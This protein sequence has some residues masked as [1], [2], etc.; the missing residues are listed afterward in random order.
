MALPTVALNEASPAGTSYIREGDDRIKEFKT[1]VREILAID[2]YFPSSGQNDAC[3]RHKWMTLIEVADIGTGADGVPIL[4]AQLVG[5]IPELCYTDQDNTDVLI[6]SKGKIALQNGRLPNNTY[7]IAR[8]AADGANIDILKVNASNII[9]LASFPITPSAAP[10]A[11]YE[12]AN[13][14]YVDDQIVANVPT[15]VPAGKVYDSDWFAVAANTGY[16]KTHN[17]GTTKLLYLIYLSIV[18]DGSDQMSCDQDMSGGYGY[19]IT[20]ITT[21]QMTITTLTNGV[22]RYGGGGSVYTSGYYRVVVL[23]LA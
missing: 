22:A 1:Q 21:T 19:H 2:H 6:T 20:S 7:L 16:T 5:I 11:D 12:V 13:K 15:N 23:A 9:E 14:K 8:N 4:G 10:D 17:L 3:G 18:G